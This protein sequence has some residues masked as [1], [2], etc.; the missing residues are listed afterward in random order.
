[1]AALVAELETTRATLASIRRER[2]VQKGLFEAGVHDLDIGA[3]MIEREAASAPEKKVAELIAELKRRKPNLFGKAAG[4]VGAAVATTP[5]ANPPRSVG[6]PGV[7]AGGSSM[8]PRAA[9]EDPRRVAAERAATTGDR[10]ALMAY[11]RVRRQN[12]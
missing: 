6:V 12:A 11:L 1:M 2:D 7:R 5:D 9:G 8:S 4:S 10:G 3:A